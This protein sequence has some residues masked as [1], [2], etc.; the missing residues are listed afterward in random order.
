MKWIKLLW[1]FSRPHTIIGSFL[2]V[3]AIY[4]MVVHP[5]NPLW[6]WNWVWLPAVLAAMGCNIFITGLNQWSDSELDQ[7]N[8]P[9]LPIPSGRLSKKA[10]LLISLFFLGFALS[11]SISTFSLLFQL[12]LLI[13]VIGAIYSLPPVKLKRHHLGA[14]FAILLVRGLLVNPGFAWVFSRMIHGRNEI[15]T[16]IWVLTAFMSL[17]GLGIAWMKDIHDTEGDREYNIG[18]LAV[19]IGK[20]TAFMYALSALSASYLLVIGISALGYLEPQWYYN[21]THAVALVWLLWK[22]RNLVIVDKPAMRS[23]YKFVW[24]LFFIEYILFAIGAF[25]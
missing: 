1:D 17:F 5:F 2:S 9:W 22:S 10:A 16:E 20:E 6:Y 7:T 25:I 12:I 24:V 4:L 14:A 11:I 21:L 19:K 3:T 8:K 23:F 13:S 18:T 15:S